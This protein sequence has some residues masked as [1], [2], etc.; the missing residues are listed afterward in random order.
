MV[1]TDEQAD[2][3]EWDAS[4]AS[5]RL[6]LSKAADVVRRDDGFGEFLRGLNYAHAMV[7]L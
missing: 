7:V 4:A 1:F 5:H 2:V 3:S 6:Q